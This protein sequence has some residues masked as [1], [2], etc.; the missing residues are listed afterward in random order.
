MLKV[1]E[2]LNFKM[3][4]EKELQEELHVNMCVCVIQHIN[5]HCASSMC[6][7]SCVSKYCLER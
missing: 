6:V 5:C 2:T 3:V 4:Q 7:C 1:R